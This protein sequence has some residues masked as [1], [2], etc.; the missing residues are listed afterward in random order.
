MGLRSLRDPLNKCFLPDNIIKV[1]G[2]GI[3][4][5]PCYCGVIFL[6][7]EVILLH[8]RQKPR[9]KYIVNTQVHWQNI[10]LGNAYL[11]LW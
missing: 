11:F 7:V 5:C 2:I 6:L 4:Y 1:L 10:L 9:H 8:R 3:A